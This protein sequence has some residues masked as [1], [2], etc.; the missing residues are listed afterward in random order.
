MLGGF[1]TNSYIHPKKV[2]SWR[3]IK[4]KKLLSSTVKSPLFF[5]R[6]RK[7]EE[8]HTP[9]HP[10]PGMV[11]LPRQRW[12]RHLPPQQVQPGQAW[13]EV[14]LLR[15]D[16][17]EGPRPHRPMGD[18]Q[19]SQFGRPQGKVHVGAEESRT[20]AFHSGWINIGKETK[21]LRSAQFHL[22]VKG[23]LDPRFALQFDGE[24]KCNPQAFQSQA[25][26]GESRFLQA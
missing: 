2:I 9:T 14:H 17:L 15:Q 10:P 12:Q 23:E 21:G 22:I 6:G 13:Q 5:N 1:K 24:P 8:R 11:S 7:G 19:W 3:K 20:C 18:N 4:I 26:T 25:F 16:L